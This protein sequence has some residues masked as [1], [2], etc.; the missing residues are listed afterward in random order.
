MRHFTL[1]N[2]AGTALDITTEDVFFYDIGGLGFSEDNDFRH[3]G[4]V[5]WLNHTSN[6]QATITG[7]MLFTE[8][9]DTDPYAKFRA[10]SEFISKAPLT[11]LYNPM[12]PIEATILGDKEDDADTF[13]RN[14]RVSKLDK[15]E[16]NEYGVIDES[17]E[18]VCYTPWYKKKISELIPKESSED[19]QDDKGWIWGGPEGSDLITYALD[20]EVDDQG[21]RVP[22]PIVFP[23]DYGVADPLVFEPEGATI[24]PDIVIPPFSG[25]YT[26]ARFEVETETNVS[27]PPLVSAI[28]SP[29][30]L[31]IYGPI[32][33]PSWIHS[34]IRNGVKT[35]IGSGAFTSTVSL[36]SKDEYL[37]VDNTGG[38]YQIY[39]HNADGTNTDLYALR[40]FGLP[41]FITL[42]EG[43]NVI[44]VV[45]KLGEPAK[46][47]RVEGHMYYATV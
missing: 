13:Y 17:I 12:R 20:S 35:T 38:Q 21:Q 24:A 44:S 28:K 10:F 22:S 18:F 4:E 46:H 32:V 2:S 27:L 1:V 7:K 39:K 6:N 40:N 47:V 25:A 37:V 29:A 15:S 42:R 14:V 41:C 19:P 8:H 9:G 5:W 33:G 36:G 26:E 34:V 30:K 16:K 45:S 23:E 3:I 31:I 11:L 43:S